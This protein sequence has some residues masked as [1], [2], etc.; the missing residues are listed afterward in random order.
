MTGYIGAAGFAMWTKV[1]GIRR[2]VASRAAHKTAALDASDPSTPTTI[3][4]RFMDADISLSFSHPK[5]YKPAGRGSSLL[6]SRETR[7]LAQP[8]ELKPSRRP[9]HDHW[10]MDRVDDRVADRTQHHAGQ[11]ASSVTA[12]DNKLSRFGLI[13]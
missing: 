11:A 5:P 12:H 9:R 3:P 8:A 10:R 1:S 13:D 6:I 2:I 4:Y 7:N